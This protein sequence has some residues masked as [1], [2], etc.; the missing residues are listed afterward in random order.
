M[1]ILDAITMGAV[2]APR[3]TLYGKPGV[4]KSTLASKFPDPLFLLTE[5]NGLQGVKTLPLITEFAHLWK[6]I[7]AL[8]DAPELPFKTLVIDSISK[9]DAL[10]IEYILD[11]EPLNKNGQK[12]STLNSACGGY[13]AGHSRAQLI[14]RNIK[15]VFDRFKERGIGVVY[16]SHLDVKK[17]KAPDNEDYDIYTIVMNH[18]KSREVYI[19]DVDLV[20]FCRL[21]SYTSETESGRTLVKSTADRVIQVGVNDAH[22]SKNRFAMPD[23]IAMSFEEIS[24]YIPFYKEIISEQN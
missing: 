11:K 18:D 2:S 3:I 1:S 23:E 9:L 5:E 16:V 21:K 20:G 7:N 15:A 13:G 6:V 12:P 10:V 4:G 24:K 8:I 14:H 22:V 17:H 19:D